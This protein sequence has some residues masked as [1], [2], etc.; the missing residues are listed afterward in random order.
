MIAWSSLLAIM[1]SVHLIAIVTIISKVHVCCGSGTHEGE[2]ILSVS[3]RTYSDLYHP[4]DGPHIT[5][6]QQET[7]MIEERRCVKNENV[8][9]GES[10]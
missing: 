1:K 3:R 4:V 8:F 7:F 2:T 10:I 9:K 6:E 5:C